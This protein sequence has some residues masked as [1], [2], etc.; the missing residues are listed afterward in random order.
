MYLHHELLLRDEYARET[1]HL[2]Q[3]E[4][5]KSAQ[6]SGKS[7]TL[8]RSPVWWKDS[9]KAQRRQSVCVRERKKGRQRQS[10]AP[11]DNHCEEKLVLPY[12]KHT[13][14]VWVA[15]DCPNFIHSSH[16]SAVSAVDQRV[17]LM[18]LFSTQLRKVKTTRVKWTSTASLT[19]FP[20]SLSRS[21]ASSFTFI[22]VAFFSS[23]NSTFTRWWLLSLPPIRW[24]SYRLFLRLSLIAFDSRKLCTHISLSFSSLQVTSHEES[25]LSALSSSIVRDTWRLK[26]LSLKICSS[27][28]WWSRL[29]SQVA[30]ERER[31]RE[32]THWWVCDEVKKETTNDTNCRPFCLSVSYYHGTE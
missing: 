15:T 28:A 9:W 26:R 10:K 22:P 32:C 14:G 27:F 21:F 30:A 5:E 7:N 20:L 17:H 2:F 19:T 31:T 3:W 16:L 1:V 11:K 8:T 25:W 6:L 23:I 29:R 24:I 18:Q 4:R 13:L 12:S